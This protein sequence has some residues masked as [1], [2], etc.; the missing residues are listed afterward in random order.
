MESKCHD[1]LS[2]LQNR[3]LRLSHNRKEK[4]DTKLEDILSGIT[5][6]FLERGLLNVTRMHLGP[7]QS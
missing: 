1:V 6:N 3:T 4:G 5:W 7:C 2:V